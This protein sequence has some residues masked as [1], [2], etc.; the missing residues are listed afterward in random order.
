MEAK[1]GSQISLH[2]RTNSFPLRK[3]YGF[4]LKTFSGTSLNHLRLKAT[5][6]LKGDDQESIR[7][8]KKLPTSEWTH[9]FHSFVV[10]VSEMDA[11]RNEID[12][13]KPKV[14][15]TIMSSQGI[16][17]TKKRILMIYMLVSL[18]LAHHF[19]EE[20]YETLRDGFGKIEEMLEDEDDLCTLSIIFWAFRRYG[21][22]ISSDVFRRFKGR[23]GNF[24]E[25][26]TG[27]AKGMLSLYEAAHLGTTKDYILQEALS[28]TSSHLE[29]LAAC[30]TCP[31]HLSVHIQN[32]LSV[33]Q[34]WNM[35]ILV[36]VEYIPFYEQEK[37]HDEILLKFA[38][39]SF[40]LLQ[41]QY[42]QD[43]KI[44]TKW[45]KELEFASKLPP[46]F[47]DN[48]V[49]NYFY[50]LAVIYTPQH[51]YER[52]MLTQYFTCL[53]ILDDTFDR[54][55][56]LPEAIS[57]ANSLERWAPNDAMDKQ[58]DYL[59]IVLNFILKTFE[60]FQKELEPEGRSYTVK[61]TIE[62]FKTVTKGNFDLAKWAHAV[63]VPSFE[64]YM[65]VGEEEISVCSTLAG[66]FMCMEQKATKEDYE[67]LKSRPKFI[68]TLC[69][70]CRL[71]NDIT[72]FEDDMSRG[73]VTNAVNCYM[74]QYGVTK[75]EAFGELNKIIVE[76]DKIL[77]EEFLTTVGVRHCVLKATFDL[78]RM[79]FITY[80]GYEG[81]T[82][83]QGKIK[84]YMTSLFVDR[85]GL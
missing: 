63:H 61:A 69:A 17:S 80:N 8:F 62:E 49:V 74:K 43:L 40:K 79:I 14:K 53:A 50:V 6:T 60:V 24:K 76:A 35:E 42:I 75:Q 57:L 54:Y 18:G 9:Y 1:F 29:S 20:I 25:S 3:L 39:L 27:Y 12:A 85:I 32:V 2:F 37:D 45:Y 82:Y 83:P 47:R 4:P 70:R 44:V 30:G 28:F 71:K 31:P 22:Y 48:I 5:N 15:N 11:L 13:L 67:W 59:K 51:S 16:D 77:N 56:S 7:K 23:N 38:K 81:F 52:I 78:A 19:E 64:E 84:E 34:H 65:K 36:P 55:A 41:L 73:Y 72:G 26:L 46:Y 10:D 66:I 33:P 21:H 58:P 68:Q